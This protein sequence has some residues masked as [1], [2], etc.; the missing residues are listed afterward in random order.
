MG[1]FVALSIVLAAGLAGL[2]SVVVSVL[3][4]SDYAEAGHVL[5]VHVLS[6][7]FV[8]LGVG[9][10]VWNAVHNQQKHAMWRTI[11]GA[12]INTGLNLVLIPSHGAMG[13]AYATVVAY[14]FS[15][16]M[17]NALSRST[18]PFLVLQ[19]RQFWPPHLIRSVMALRAD[20]LDR[21]RPPVAG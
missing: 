18:W 8:F 14:A 21:F 1:G 13:A 16:F 7:P 3:Y 5:R 15:G 12:V 17:G 6:L 19:A 11:G 9:Q 20:V 2:S 4:G 10:T